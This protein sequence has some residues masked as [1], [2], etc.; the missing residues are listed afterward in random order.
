M[1]KPTIPGELQNSD[2]NAISLVTQA[3]N[4]EKFKIFKSAEENV[5]E[6]G[7]KDE[8][9]LFTTLKN[10]FTG[11]KVEKGVVADTMN[12]VRHGEKL[13]EAFQALLQE[14]AIITATLVYCC[15]R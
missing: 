2:V 3:A 12:S 5:P 6:A 13:F 15:V 14:V 11:E 4:G 1:S 10:F 9:G 7:T 8:R